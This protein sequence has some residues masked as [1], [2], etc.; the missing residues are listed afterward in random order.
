MDHT[1]LEVQWGLFSSIKPRERKYCQ[2]MGFS[3]YNSKKE[4]Y[5][6]EVP[7]TVPCALPGGSPFPMPQHTISDLD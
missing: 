7:P 6:A 4:N 2:A 3:S 5:V 1:I